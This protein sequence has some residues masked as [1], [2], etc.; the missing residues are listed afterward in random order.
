MK[1]NSYNVKTH[2]LKIIHNNIDAWNLKKWTTGVRRQ[3]ETKNVSSV[4]RPALRPTQSPI[5]GYRVFSQVV[6]RGRGVTLTTHP[7]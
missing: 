7:I 2:F 3:P 1:Q 4:S 5:D 6:K